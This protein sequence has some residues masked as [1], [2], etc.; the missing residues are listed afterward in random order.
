MYPVLTLLFRV[1]DPHSFDPDPDLTF[2]AEYRTDQDPDPIRIQNFDDHKLQSKTT[3]YLSLHKNVQVT[4]EALSS[5]KRTSST[6]KHEI[7]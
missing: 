6:S 3:T 4:E 1:A 7:S 5:Q 2:Q